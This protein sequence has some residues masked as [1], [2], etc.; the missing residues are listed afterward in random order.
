MSSTILIHMIQST[1]H[2]ETASHTISYADRCQLEDIKKYSDS[3][4]YETIAST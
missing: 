2:T 3:Q 4:W 1:G